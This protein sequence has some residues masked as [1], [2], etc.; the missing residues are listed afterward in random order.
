VDEYLRLTRDKK[1][2]DERP[3]AQAPRKSDGA[4][5][6]VDAYRIKKEIASIERKLHTL[7]SRDAKLT[8]RMHEADPTD[9]GQLVSLGEQQREL[10]RQV[11]E[12]ELEWLEKSERLDS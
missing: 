4:A 8:E 5:P 1:R 6:E 7:Q 11:E 3:E 2:Q 9:Y 10:R 12:Y